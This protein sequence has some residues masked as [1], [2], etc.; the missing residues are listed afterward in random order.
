VPSSAILIS[1]VLVFHF[2]SFILLIKHRHIKYNEYNDDVDD[3]DKN[4][5]SRTARLKIKR[6]Q[7]PL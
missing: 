7:L 3:D 1:A 2:I 5:L 4:R 6:S